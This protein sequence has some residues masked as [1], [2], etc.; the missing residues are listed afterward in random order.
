MR[1]SRLVLLP[2]TARLAGHREPLEVVFEGIETAEQLAQLRAL[3]CDSGQGFYFARPLP[4]EAAS[5]L[6]RRQTRSS[7]DRLPAAA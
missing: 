3:G 5:D 6:L 2:V 4:A 7:D 1:A